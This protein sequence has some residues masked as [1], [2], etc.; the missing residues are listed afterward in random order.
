MS[1]FGLEQMETFGLD[2][3]YVP[4][5]VDTGLFRPRPDIRDEVRDELGIPQDVFLV[6]MVAANKSFPAQ[7]RKNF[8]G[9]LKA[10]SAFARRHD[11]AWFYVHTQARGAAGGGVKLD[12]LAEA[13]GCPPGRVRFPHDET[14]HLG[15]PAAAVAM[16]Y[17]AFD[18]MLMP[19]RGEGFG[20]PLLEAQASGVP[21]IASDHSAM[22]ELNG[23]GWLVEGQPD[24]DEAQ[25]SWFIMPFDTSILAALDAAYEAR[26]DQELRARAREF[27]LAYDADVVADTYWKPVLDEL[28]APVEAAA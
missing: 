19:S 7:D 23:A 21:V 11:D 13:T 25:S 22:T 28:L 6:G 15:I 5:G 18:V 26:G 10:F 1:R 14:F 4:H 12:V 3:L 16:L 27:A 20:I 2:P 24:W 17:Q 9:A 8:A